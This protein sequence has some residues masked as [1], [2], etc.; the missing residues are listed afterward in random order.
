MMG[1]LEELVQEAET[2]LEGH[3]GRSGGGVSGEMEEQGLV[4]LISDQKG[5]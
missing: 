1:R 2:T 4:V 3:V 5:E